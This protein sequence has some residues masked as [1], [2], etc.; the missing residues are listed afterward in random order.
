[1][2]IGAGSGWSPQ[3]CTAPE[4]GGWMLLL[5]ILLLP[6]RPL[7]I[8]QRRKKGTHNCRSAHSLGMSHT[9]A[10]TLARPY[11]STHAWQPKGERVQ[12]QPPTVPHPRSA[13]AD[14][15]KLGEEKIGKRSKGKIGPR[16]KREGGNTVASNFQRE[17]TQSLIRS[18]AK[19]KL[20]FSFW[21]TAT[22]ACTLL[23]LFCIVNLV[24]NKQPEELRVL[25]ERLV[26]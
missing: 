1:M 14:S 25:I 13:A 20:F 5:F 19:R 8:Q 2:V 6:P 7:W 3:L 15:I 17:H 4:P 26:L 18:A 23:C 10:G 11:A 12:P 9:K 16:S 22:T 21:G 24:L